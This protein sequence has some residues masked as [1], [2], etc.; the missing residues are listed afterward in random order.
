MGGRL[1]TDNHHGFDMIQ[2]GWQTVYTPHL[3]Y[4][5]ISRIYNFFAGVRLDLVPDAQFEKS[6]D[7]GAADGR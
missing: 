5:E 2:D 4:S 6:G 1:V 3:P 7:G